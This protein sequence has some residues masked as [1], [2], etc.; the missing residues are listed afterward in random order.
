MIPTNA[1]LV[2]V[3]AHLMGQWPDEID[4][5]LGGSK[6]TVTIKDMNSM[7][8]VTIQD[9]MDADLVVASFSVLV[10]E[11]YYIRLARLSGIDSGSL[12]SGT[13]GGRHFDSVYEEACISLGERVQQIVN[14]TKDAHRAIVETDK[15]SKSRASTDVV[16]MDGKRAAY[17]PHVN[18]N[19][20]KGKNAGESKASRGDPWGLATKAVQSNYVKMMCPPLE[21]FHWTRLVVDE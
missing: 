10:N 17:Q 11:E 6:K 7:N 8:R 20:K 14:S 3:P 5:F 21:C 1:T 2:I 9:I 15:Q 12:P 13:T 18:N 19:E 4:K 16:T